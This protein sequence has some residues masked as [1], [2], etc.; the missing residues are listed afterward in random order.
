MLLIIPPPA[1][2]MDVV[3]PPPQETPESMGVEVFLNIVK[4]LQSGMLPTIEVSVPM[5]RIKNDTR[6]DGIPEMDSEDEVM[7]RQYLNA[8]EAERLAENDEQHK[9]KMRSIIAQCVGLGSIG[10][11]LVLSVSPYF[12]ALV[13]LFLPLL[14][15]VKKEL[16]RHRQ[17]HKSIKR[18][19]VEQLAYLGLCPPLPLQRD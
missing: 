13:F 11:A 8:E 18:Q 10:S 19:K 14:D 15:K 5:P 2:L 1:M 12:I 7:V 16:L 3:A 6:F 9:K 4:S 17:T